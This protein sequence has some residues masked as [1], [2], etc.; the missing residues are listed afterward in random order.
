MSASNLKALLEKATQ[1][2][3]LHARLNQ[4]ST[5]SPEAALAEITQISH[6]YDLPI[7]AQELA[8]ALQPTPADLTD[9]DLSIISGGANPVHQQLATQIQSR[10]NDEVNAAFQKQL[11]GL[12]AQLDAVL[13]AAGKQP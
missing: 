4:I 1:D 5:Q 12:Q 7:T 2:T 11:S 10:I 6:D 8:D 9:A 3:V 13:K